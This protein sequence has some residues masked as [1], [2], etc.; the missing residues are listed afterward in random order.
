MHHQSQAGYVFVSI[1]CAQQLIKTMNNIKFL[2]QPMMQVLPWTTPKIISSIS[3]NFIYLAN[4]G[5]P[6]YIPWRLSSS[7]WWACQRGLSPPAGP[8]CG[9]CNSGSVFITINAPLILKMR[10]IIFFLRANYIMGHFKGYF[11]GAKTFL[12]PKLSRAQRGTILRGQLKVCH[13]CHWHRWQT[14]SC[15][16]LRE[17]SKKFE[18]I[19]MV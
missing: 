15:E 19:L 13:R 12:T 16:Y 17:F 3:H 9:F 7:A 5:H 6:V 11:E 8:P 2:V 10:D 1:I 4:N 14:L 18:T